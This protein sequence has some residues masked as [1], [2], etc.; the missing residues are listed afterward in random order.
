MHIFLSTPTLLKWLFISFWCYVEVNERMQKPLN[1]KEYCRIQLA[2]LFFKLI[3]VLDCFY[4]REYQ[5]KLEKGN[6]VWKCR[7]ERDKSKSILPEHGIF[8]RK[9]LKDVNKQWSFLLSVFVWKTSRSKAAL[10]ADKI[11]PYLTTSLSIRT[12]Y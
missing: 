8:S 3:S 7:F 2:L 9:T 11:W 4:V 6:K 5:E 10:K 1:L 12:I